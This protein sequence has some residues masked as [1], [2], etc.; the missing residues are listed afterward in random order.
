LPIGIRY[1]FLFAISGE[2]ASGVV[3]SG[4]V[5]LPIINTVF[6]LATLP[7]GFSVSVRRLHDLD[8]SAFGGHW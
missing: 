1:W 2:L 8:R 6:I 4:I 7:P 3:D 5:G